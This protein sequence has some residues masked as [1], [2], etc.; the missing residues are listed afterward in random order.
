MSNPIIT[1]ES[2]AVR[3]V[4]ARG[5]AAFLGVP[6]AAAPVG[7]NRFAPPKPCPA[8][9]GERDATAMGP[10]APYRLRS[11]DVIDL[12]PL[13]GDGWR[14]GDDY[15]NANI[16]T[17][18]PIGSGRPVLVFIHGGAFVGGCNAAAV[19]NGSAFARDGVICVTINYRMAINGFLPIPGVPTNLGLRDQLAALTWV[20]ANAR[21]FGGDPDNITVAGESAGAMSI[22]DLVASPLAKGL[23]RR[24]IIQSGHG[25]MVRAIPVAERVTAKLAELLGAP[26]TR[27]GFES[28]TQEQWLDAIETVQLPTTKIDLKNRKGREPASGLSK[29]LP[30]Y[31]DDVL[32]KPPLEALAEGAGADIDVLIGTNAEE[33]NIYLVPTG[34]TQKLSRLL[35]WFLF[36]RTEPKAGA[37]L[38]D[39]RRALPGKRP[40]EVLSI[41]MGDLAFRWPARAY[42]QAHRGRTHFYEFDWPSTAFEGRLGACHA[43]DLPFVFDTLDTC[44]GPKG[45]AGEA[46]PQMLADR[47]HAIWADYA[48]DGSLPWREYDAADQTVFSLAR[49]EAGRD[50]DIPAAKYWS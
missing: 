29:F 11:M 8:W 46:P 30:V 42:A 24:A 36:R 26:A 17:P 6:Y 2:G 48:R 33:M 4:A 37:I 47:V 3:G 43:L 5:V 49:G 27:E 28:R 19:Q 39:Y 38:R 18:D 40:G 35:S 15:L 20:K 16:W 21:A 9:E 14:Q 13:V 45:V 1:V 22:A 34:V 31:G 12:T 7:E 23:F 41:A 44:T 10:S 32:P 50:P 25:S